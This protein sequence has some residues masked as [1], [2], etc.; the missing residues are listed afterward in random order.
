[1]EIRQARPADRPA[2]RDV[3]RR[4]L[5]ASYSLDTGAITTAV[6][7]WYDEEGLL[8]TFDSES[9]ELLVADR[10]GRAVGFVELDRSGAG[11][12]ATLL[13]LHVDPSY[14]GEGI[15]STLFDDVRSRLEADGVQRVYG[16]VLADNDEGNDF[17]ADHGFQ[18]VGEKE[19]DIGGGSYVE[20]LWLD[21]EETGLESIEAEGRTLFVNR[22]ESDTGSKDSFYVVYTDSDR[23]DKYGYYC[24]NCGSLAN[25][26]DASGRVECDECGNFRKATRWDAAYL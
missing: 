17:Y 21:A 2:I 22:A 13:W 10:D 25:A 18:R 19:L 5:E 15:A 3:A 4:S 7:Q 16:R 20:N 1:M 9:H 11:E 6:E 8:E 12:E 14:R 23:T 24:G 26:M